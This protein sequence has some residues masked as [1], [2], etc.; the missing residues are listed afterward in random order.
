MV[1]SAL[2]ERV[3]Y[4]DAQIQVT[5]ESLEKLNKTHEFLLQTH[6]KIKESGADS[7]ATL[8]LKIG[9]L[10][11]ETQ[12]KRIKMEVSNITKAID[13][14]LAE[15]KMEKQMYVAEVEVQSLNKLAAKKNMLER[16]QMI[17]RQY[18]EM[19]VDSTIETLSTVN[20]L[21]EIHGAI[22]R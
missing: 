3:S 11:T 7:A 14:S 6:R 12:M 17:H 9:V 13:I 21:M 15:E 19:V 18:M 4:I 5:T 22:K 8:A 1:L 2:A 10:E 16:N 20:E